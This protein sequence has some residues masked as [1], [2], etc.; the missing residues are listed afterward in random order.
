M[1][2][3]LCC[4]A[5]LAQD[6]PPDPFT[7]SDYDEGD[8]YFIRGGARRPHHGMREPWVFNRALEWTDAGGAVICHAGQ[9]PLL[10]TGRRQ[11]SRWFTARA[12]DLSEADDETTRL[13]K[14]DPK[15][16][17]DHASLPPF[18]FPIEQFPEAE[19]EVTEASHPWQFLV[20]VKGRSGPPF[21]AGPWREGPGK[22]A[23]DLL[24]RY[25]AKGY[26]HHFAELQFF[27]AVWT[28][29]PAREAAV[30]FR[31]R[32]KG[33]PAIVPSLPVIRTAERARKEGVPLAAVVVDG[34]G[35]RQGKD[36]V[37]V[38]A[39]IGDA[40]VPMSDGGDGVWKGMVRDLP[41]GDHR[42]EFRASW[43]DGRGGT[44]TTSLD[45]HV[46]DGL[47]IGYDPQLRLLTRAGM[48]LG[49]LSGSYRGAP[50][51]TGIG[52]PAESPVQGQEAWDAVKGD[53]WGGQHSNFGGGRYGF[54]W[55]ESLTPKE[56]EA[57]HAY[58]ARCGWGIVH[59]CQGW[60]VW[61]RLD[62][63][64]HLAPHG[65]EQLAL[66]A[67]TARRHGLR[68]LFAV[69]HY[70]LGK[71]AAPWAQYL[72]AGY[73]PADYRDPASKFYS[74]FR[75]YLAQF[76]AVFRDET[77]L[78]GFTAAG[79]GD[80]ACG[81]TFVNE[82]HDALKARDPNHLVLGEPHHAMN[83][84]PLYHVQAG[85]KPRLAGMR[86]Y[87][88]DRKPLEA[89]GAQF[90][91]A[92]LGD[93][94]MGEGVFWGYSGGPTETM[95]YR[96]R[97]RETFSIGFAHRSPILLTWEARV[98]EDEHRVLDE[99]R[100]SIDWSRPFARPRVAVRAGRESLVDAG[101]MALARYEAAFSRMPL[102]YACVWEDGEAPPGALAVLDARQP[103]AEPAF[104]SEG[105]PLPDALRG[106]MPLRLPAGFA[107]NYSWS[108]DRCQ[109]IAFL[110]RAEAPATPRAGA[111]TTEAGPFTYADTTKAFERDT[112]VDAWEVRCARPGAVELCIFRREGDD[113][114][115]AGRSGRVEMKRPGL[116][117]FALDRPIAAKKGD[118]VGLHIPG[119]ATHVA[120]AEGGRILFLEKREPE[121]RVPLSS[122]K[123]EPKILDLRA[124][125][126]AEAAPPV[127]PPAAGSRI[128]LQNFPD[129]RLA[130]RLYDLSEKRIA[131][132]GEF[133]KSRELDAPPSGRHFFLVVSGAR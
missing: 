88:I 79:E 9:S 42:A 41:G 50:M 22:L 91:L 106:D 114:A 63:G 133:R 123:S 117:R 87:F 62:A 81:M 94:F 25:R 60:W 52:T 4:L 20:A 90:K 104:A 21:F 121:P 33:V 76:T 100:R 98:A 115:L 31:L 30:S 108:G 32:L 49:P 68:V 109:L 58:L 95:R 103:Y 53:A 3:V 70:P 29:D 61:E 74:M 111:E 64:G 73:R 127:R 13:V 66:V 129:S 35:R 59:L 54:Q 112:A 7:V 11:V 82:V 57:D 16:D 102:E 105:G 126:S 78:L 44:P 99:V 72:E 17:T 132:E 14:K 130:W 55:W 43:K 48:P 34:R 40:A 2:A 56:L 92:G 113:L 51:F 93:L 47:F 15:T 26:R 67:A 84:D 97:I 24:A 39:R 85:W 45:V 125:S 5:L 27:V 38:E 36:A 110:R 116:C 120:A 107:A 131:A 12:N 37:S 96:E 101:K 69:S 6:A 71:V 65:A 8:V 77:G 10:L 19:L 122:W 28:K 46:T 119:E 1:N 80:P 124:F 23:V 118:L 18:Q 128:V 89:V 86:T 83:K 75:D